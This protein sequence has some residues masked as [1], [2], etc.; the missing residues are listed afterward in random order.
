MINKMETQNNNLTQKESKLHKLINY[1]YK[2]LY[3]NFE[4]K[5]I[6][7]SRIVDVDIIIKWIK[8]N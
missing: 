2:K 8:Q 4:K 5:D 3:T 1:Y 7:Q 6:I